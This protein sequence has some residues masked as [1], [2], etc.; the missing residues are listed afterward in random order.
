MHKR[1]NTEFLKDIQEAI[2][3]IENYIEKLDYKKFLND[4]K[5][6]DA[7][8][9]NIEIIGEAVKNITIDFKKR[10]SNIERVMRDRVLRADSV[11]ASK[12]MLGGFTV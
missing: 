12:D 6:Q 4:T 7:T 1:G 3:R 9:R 2:K 8:V 11:C 10:Y 5:T